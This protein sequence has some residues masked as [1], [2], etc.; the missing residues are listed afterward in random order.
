MWAFE[1]LSSS[2]GSRT[3]PLFYAH[4]CGTVEERDIEAVNESTSFVE[5]PRE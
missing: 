4:S 3:C 1:G 2:D 5:R